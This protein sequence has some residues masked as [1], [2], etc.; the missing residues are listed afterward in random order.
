MKAE[1]ILKGTEERLI[2][3]S[4]NGDSI[5]IFPLIHLLLDEILTDSN[6]FDKKC[7]KNI[8]NDILNKIDK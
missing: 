4:I 6:E 8:C 7:L 1:I 3:Y 5:I 2:E